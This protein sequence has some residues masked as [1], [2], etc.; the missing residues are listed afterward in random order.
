MLTSDFLT[1]N[2]IDITLPFAGQ[3]YIL[4]VENIKLHSTHNNQIE[5]QFLTNINIFIQFFCQ[6]D[7]SLTPHGNKFI[8][9]NQPHIGNF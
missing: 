6:I 7:S 1:S 3:P 5:S 9:V 2:L 8:F 4:F